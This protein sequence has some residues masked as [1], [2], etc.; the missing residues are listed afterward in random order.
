MRIVQMKSLVTKLLG[1]PE[2]IGMNGRSPNHDHR[3]MI[4]GN[5][6][7]KVYLHH[8]PNDASSLDLGPYPEGLISVGLAKSYARESSDALGVLGGREAWM[9]LIAKS[10]HGSE[11]IP[12]N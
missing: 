5:Q 6:Y 7:F 4:F 12:H 1:P 11:T 2:E 9:V 3:W 8:S 10:A